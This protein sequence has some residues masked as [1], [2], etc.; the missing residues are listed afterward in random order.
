MRPRFKYVG[1]GSF[2]PGIPARDLDDEDLRQMT[3]EQRRELEGS[4]I[5]EPVGKAERPQA[6]EEEG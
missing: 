6:E 5:Y 2:L 1:G 3:E 4:T